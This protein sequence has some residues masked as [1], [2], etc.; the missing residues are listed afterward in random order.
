[1]YIA[2]HFQAEFFFSLE[3]Y[4]ILRANNEKMVLLQ[5]PILMIFGLSLFF[6]VSLSLECQHM[7]SNEGFLIWDFQTEYEKQPFK[8]SKNKYLWYFKIY[9]DH[10]YIFFPCEQVGRNTI[11][12]ASKD[13]F[14]CDIKWCISPQNV[15]PDI[16]VIMF[17]LWIWYPSFIEDVHQTLVMICV[18]QTPGSHIQKVVDKSHYA[19]G[20]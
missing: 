6:S 17:F 8:L 4:H 2:L 15:L 19:T 13:A 9:F 1:M 3:S 5:S 16:K 11:F 18:H 7:F 14:H 20:M 12:L 10:I